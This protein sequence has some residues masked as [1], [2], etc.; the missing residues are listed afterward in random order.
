MSTVHDQFVGVADEATY[1][2]AVA[3]DN[4]YE[5]LSESIDGVYERIESEAIRGPVLRADRFAPNPKGAGGDFEVEVLDKGFEFWL[6]HIFGEVVTTGDGSTTPFEHTA[7]LGDL[8][9]K[10][11]TLQVGRQASETANLIPF[12]YAGGKVAEWEFSAE[13]DGIVK[14]KVTGDFASETIDGTGADALAVPSYPASTQLLTFIGAACTIGGQSFAVTSFT[15]AGSNGLKVD[16]YAMRGSESTTKREPRIEG[17]REIT[18]NIGSEFENTTNME[19]VAASIAA[20]ALAEISFL[21]NSPQGG[22]LEFVLPAARFD[23]GPV[24]AARELTMQELSGKVLDPG[25]PGET[26]TARYLPAA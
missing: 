22:E 18:F 5:I 24:N 19:R 13:V 6:N 9:N 25:L 21:F 4:F 17:L 7:T 23:E 26:I 11:F 3:P 12:S 15:L 10:S 14:A 16:R 20:G 1:G 2:T 8:D